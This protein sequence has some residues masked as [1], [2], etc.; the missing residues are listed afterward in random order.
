[1]FCEVSPELA[2]ERGLVNGGWATITTAR[3]EIAARVLVTS[4]LRPLR[5]GRRVVHQ[6]GLPYHWGNRGLARGDATNEL[7]GF[8]GDPNVTIQESKALTASIAPGRRSHGRRAPTSGPEADA[9]GPARRHRDLERAASEPEGRH[10][11]R[12][13]AKKEGEQS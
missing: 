8:V 5:L 9:P 10:G 4:R 11:M 1:M 12:A 6:I 7:I 3:A 2:A 13:S